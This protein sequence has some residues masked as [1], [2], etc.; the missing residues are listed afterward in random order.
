MR[1]RLRRLLSTDWDY[2]NLRSTKICDLEK[3]FKRGLTPAI[4][5]TIVLA[6]FPGEIDSHS[7]N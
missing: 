7:T 2:Q 5:R 3:I 1:S 4:S 6:S